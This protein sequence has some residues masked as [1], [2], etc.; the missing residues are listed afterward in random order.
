MIQV[1]C[2]A[3][4]FIRVYPMHVFDVCWWFYLFDLCRYLMNVVWIHEAA[5]LLCLIYTCWPTFCLWVC[6]SVTSLPESCD[7]EHCTFYYS[8]CLRLGWRP[9]VWCLHRSDIWWIHVTALWVVYSLWR[10]VHKTKPAFVL[11]EVYFPSGW[12]SDR[13]IVVFFLASPVRQ[14]LL[15][16]FW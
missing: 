11:W 3:C 10:E 4:C 13:F 14:N 9:S 1:F 16:D 15:S 6:P 12:R 7:L 2:V 5:I 8:Q